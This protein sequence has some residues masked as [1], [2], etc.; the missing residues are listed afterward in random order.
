M[1]ISADRPGNVNFS[2]RP[3]SAHRSGF[4]APFITR[5]GD[6]QLSLYGTVELGVIE[7][8]ARLLVRAEGGAVEL[9][10]TIATVTGADAAQPGVDDLPC[11]HLGG[12]A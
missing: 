9:G 1:R 10:D 5:V 7:F 4:N 8:E 2:V 3:T 11:H 6:D 12:V